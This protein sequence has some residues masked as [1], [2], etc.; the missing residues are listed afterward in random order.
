M[1]CKKCGYEIKEGEQFCSKCG[2]KVKQPKEENYNKK[3][4]KTIIALIVLVILITAMAI[5]V[6]NVIKVVKEEQYKKEMQI[7]L[8]NINIS[9][10][11]QE[12]KLPYQGKYDEELF[13]N[14]YNLNLE[15]ISDYIQ[16]ENI[17]ESYEG[18][19]LSISGNIDINKIGEYE[20]T[21]IV[22]SEKGNNKN[23][24]LIVKVQDM[25]KPIINIENETVTV[26]KGTEI[27][28]LEG[29]TVSDNLDSAEELTTKITTEGSVDTNTV[30]NYI[31]KYKITDNAGLNNE[32]TR[33]YN[34]VETKTIKVGKTYTYRKYN[35]MYN[36]GY[37]DLTVTFKAGNKIEYKEAMDMDFFIYTGSYSI[38]N[39]V[40][41]AKVSYN[42][43]V[44]RK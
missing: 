1:N 32:K 5:L 16:F 31:I 36:N 21:Y 3:K 30:G 24:K 44:Q 41:T 12:I 20:V 2:K 34:V 40:I 38:N 27:N 4:T 26:N 42:N 7:D 14:T 29:V 39:G 35:E 33:T 25:M 6:P 17:I 22:T 13:K 9:L 8:N 37:I 43:V 19:T 11:E 23:E 18:G 15:N 28:L 10:K